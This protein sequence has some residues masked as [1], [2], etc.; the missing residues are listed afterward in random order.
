MAENL[1]AGVQT[2]GAIPIVISGC[3]YF[4]VAP[5]GL[6]R[7]PFGFTHRI[8]GGFS[9]GDQDYVLLRTRECGFSKAPSYLPSKLW[10][11]IVAHEIGHYLGLFH[12]MELDGRR[13]HLG[14]IGN[15]NLMNHSPTQQGSGTKLTARQ[16]IVARSH[17]YL[18]HSGD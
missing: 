16:R 10:A 3:S 15:H 2:E 4:N 7:E 1:L 13:H 12:T 8:P 9:F 6:R 17:P 18:V 11:R 5:S 14:S